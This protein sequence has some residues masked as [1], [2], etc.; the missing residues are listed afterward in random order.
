MKINPR[1]YKIEYISDALVYELR[2]QLERE[3]YD[4]EGDDLNTLCGGDYSMVTETIYAG[5][6][7]DVQF[8]IDKKIA[9]ENYADR[10]I[11][12]IE[13]WAVVEDGEV[14]YHP[15]CYLPE[16]PHNANVIEYSRFDWL[17]VA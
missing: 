3:G 13:E 12:I 17:E 9:Y 4:V 10:E 5:S 6:L 1:R 16:L 7:D 11:T 14:S 2:K 15:A 8:Y